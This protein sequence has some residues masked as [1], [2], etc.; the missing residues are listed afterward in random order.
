[1]LVNHIR[2]IT[3]R[4]VVKPYC[5]EPYGLF[6]TRRSLWST[7]LRSVFMTNVSYTKKLGSFICQKG[8][9]YSEIL[10]MHQ[11]YWSSY[12]VDI[13]VAIWVE[14]GREVIS[15]ALYVRTYIQTFHKPHLWA[16]K[17]LKLIIRL[18]SQNRFFTITSV[19]LLLYR[20]YSTA[21]NT[22]ASSKVKTSY[23]EPSC[24]LKQELTSKVVRRLTVADR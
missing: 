5:R 11:W 4:D 8:C 12:L 17:T 10:L 15:L 13:F 7:S 20:V 3:W 19:S 16:Q 9:W 23:A 14:I 18:K 6:L 2:I 22:L 1:M 24:V 21:Y